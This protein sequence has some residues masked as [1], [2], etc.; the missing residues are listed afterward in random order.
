MLLLRTERLPEGPDWLYEVKLD[1]Y[2]ALAVKSGGNVQLRSRNDNDFSTRYARLTKALNAM[3]DET[4]IDGEVVALDK[5]GKPSFNALQN[6]GSS[7]GPMLYYAFDVLILSGRDVMGETLDVRRAL[8]EKNVLAKLDERPLGQA[9]EVAAKY[10]LLH[11]RTERD[12][13]PGVL[14]FEWRAFVEG[15]EQQRDRKTADCT[16]AQG[17]RILASAGP[18]PMEELEPHRI[19]ATAACP[20]QPQQSQCEYHTGDLKR[21]NRRREHDPI[22][23]LRIASPA[24]TRCSR[25]SVLPTFFTGYEHDCR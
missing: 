8:L 23:Y 20:C 11:K 19:Q 14:P 25:S 18:V 9:E 15:L 17:L 13:D 12:S 3:P 4:V 5:D 21:M 1:G 22:S 7:S 6:Y 24:P 2:R 10:G 16:E